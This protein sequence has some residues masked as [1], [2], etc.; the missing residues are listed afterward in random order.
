MEESPTSSSNYYCDYCAKTFSGKYTFDKHLSVCKFFKKPI[1]EQDQDD[2]LNK[3]GEPLPSYLEMFHLMKNLNARV[4]KLEKENSLLL[5]SCPKRSKHVDVLTCLNSP[6]RKTP[7]IPF[8]K[9]MREHVLPIVHESLPIVFSTDLLSAAQNVLKQAIDDMRFGCGTCEIP[10]KVF[11]N[12]QDEFYAFVEPDNQWILLNIHQL[13]NQMERI[14]KKF[15]TDFNMF[16]LQPNRDKIDK[17]ETYKDMYVLY[18]KKVLGEGTE[19]TRCKKIRQFLYKE[20]KQKKE[21]LL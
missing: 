5:K 10:L 18:Y 14:F 6:S 19:D 3:I 15:L 8:L 9:W 17:E 11:Q 2:L 16:W 12:K 7:E 21:T 13:D 1:R 4:E 20:L